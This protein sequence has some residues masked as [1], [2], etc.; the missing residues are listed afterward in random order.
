MT[1]VDVLILH[2]TPAGRANEIEAW[3]ADARSALAERHRVGFLAAGAGGAT[4]VAG[5]PDDRSFGERLAPIVAGRRSD[6]LVVLGSG[7]IPLATLADRRAFVAAAA[8]SGRSALANNRYSADVVAI[9]RVRDLPPVPDLATDNALP[10][11]LIEQAGWD[12]TDLRG[13]WR[14]GVDIDGPLELALVG[15]RPWVPAAPAALLD[16]VRDRLRAI[17]AIAR[18]P[19]AELVVAGR[20]SAATLGWLERSTDSRTRALIEERGVRTR[21]AGQRPAASVLGMLLDQEGP[22]A[23]GTLL[24]RLGDAAIVDTRVLLAHRCGTDEGAWPAAAD[25]FASDLLLPDRIVDPWLRA[26]TAAA[27]DGSIPVLLG[28]HSLVGPGLRLALGGTPPWT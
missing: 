12:V 16:V 3:V 7:A 11:W 8:A 19:H 20:M 18:D 9:G 17:R 26:L 25:R 6:G 13:R 2:P 28:G 1:D 10:R 4:V 23:F 14:L 24:A 5:P 21:L 27:I 22:A 15:P